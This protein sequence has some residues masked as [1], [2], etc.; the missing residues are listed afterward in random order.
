ML[1]RGK[2]NNKVPVIKPEDDKL[3]RTGTAGGDGEMLP[4]AAVFYGLYCFSLFKENK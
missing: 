1:R 3:G 4:E 2:G